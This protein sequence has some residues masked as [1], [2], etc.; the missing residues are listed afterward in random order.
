M[1]VG[2]PGHVVNGLVSQ[3]YA[4]IIVVKAV[5]SEATALMIGIIK[6]RGDPVVVVV[7]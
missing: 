6:K 5:A 2:T 4:V 1:I 3:F 7:N